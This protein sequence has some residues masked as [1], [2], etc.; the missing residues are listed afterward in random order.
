MSVFI[1]YSRGDTSFVEQIASHFINDGLIVSLDK[2]GVKPGEMW[3]PKIQKLIQ[4]SFCVLVV[5]SPESVTSPN[6]LN[7]LS[8]ALDEG[9]TVVPLIIRDCQIPLRLCGIEYCDFRQDHQGGIKALMRAIRPTL[10]H[11]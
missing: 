5:L 2:T 6:V 7:E 1:S 10:G 3:A 8:F 9:K 4:E 11:S